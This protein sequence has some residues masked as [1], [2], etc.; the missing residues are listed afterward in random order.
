MRYDVEP[1]I[2]RLISAERGKTFVSSR[3][4]VQTRGRLARWIRLTFTDKMSLVL[5]V[6]FSVPVYSG[7]KRKS[8]NDYPDF[9]E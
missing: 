9:M 3:L 4:N 5:L 2:P 1:D 6:L 7:Y 8:L